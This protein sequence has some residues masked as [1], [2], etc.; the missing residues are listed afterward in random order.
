MERLGKEER[1]RNEI[2]CEAMQLNVHDAT[3]NRF[4]GFE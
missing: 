1:T 2:F 4:V 3:L